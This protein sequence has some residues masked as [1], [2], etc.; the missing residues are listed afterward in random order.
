MC[1]VAG[2]N[3]DE[4]QSACRWRTRYNIVLIVIV[5]GVAYKMDTIDG[6]RG[7]DDDS[8]LCDYSSLGWRLLRFITGHS[9]SVPGPQ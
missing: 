6:G 7:V 2:C 3:F 4:V 5:G 8:Q 9:S 1:P